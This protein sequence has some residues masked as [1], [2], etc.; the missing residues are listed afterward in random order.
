MQIKIN[1][2]K[3]HLYILTALIVVLA[4]TVLVIGYEKGNPSVYG[5][6]ADEINT[7][8]GD[9]YGT[10]GEGTYSFPGTSKLGIGTTNP[11]TSRLKV[12]GT[13]ANGI[14]YKRT[15]AKDARIMVG[16]P[17]KTWSIASGWSTAGD[18]S[19]IEEGVAGHRLYIK[20]GG[21]VGIGTEDPK[22][23]LDVRGAIRQVM[24]VNYDLWLQ[25][26]ASTSSGDD[27]NLAILGLDEDYGDKLIINHGSEYAGGTEIQSALTVSGAVT[28]TSF[29]GDGSLLTSVTDSAHDECSEITDC[30]PSAWDSN[31]DLTANQI[32]EGKIDFD[33]S[34]ASGNH[35]YV[36][37][38]DLACETDANTITSCDWTGDQTISTYTETATCTRCCSG[39]RNCQGGSCYKIRTRTLNGECSGN[40]LIQMN[41]SGW[42]SY[43]SCTCTGY[44]E[45]SS[46]FV[47]GTKVTM[48]DNSLKN[49]EDIQVGEMVKSFDEAT[50]QIGIQK[51]SGIESPIREGYYN[52][53]FG[54]NRLVKVTNEHPFY[55]KKSDGSVGWCS[56]IPEITRS[57][58]P[59]LY[60]IEQLEA[61]DMIYTDYREWVEVHSWDY[62]EGQ[63]QTY[64][65]MIENTPTYFAN[66]LLAHNKN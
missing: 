36:S 41:L 8:T 32:S 12:E 10:F 26:G 55:T 23:S 18:F 52:L 44:C 53:Y 5:H 49:I 17:T 28:A 24:N 15:D 6:T 50:K 57:F 25:G 38:N 13:V 60:F 65:L 3:K 16:D 11:G 58:Y 54:D 48:A 56:I 63:I 64:N 62:I 66:G 43:G 19:I 51:V 29:S 40:T 39:G 47:A 1:F 2:M 33:T 7:G 21:N 59:H 20:Q 14:V 9:A 37:G 30:V 46:C 61:G 27:R 34:C 45:Y 22:Q 42:G 31:S 4:G 35:L